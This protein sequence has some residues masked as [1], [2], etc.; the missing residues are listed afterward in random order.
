[1]KEFNLK[2]ISEFLDKNPEATYNS[3]FDFLEI[4]I[5]HRSDYIGAA[6]FHN[7]IKYREEL[8]EKELFGDTK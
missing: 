4:P 6:I 5:E 1:M 2:E 7:V 8:L 3:L